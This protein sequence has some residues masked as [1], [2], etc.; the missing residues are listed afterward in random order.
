MVLLFL[1]TGHPLY[2]GIRCI[3][4][5]IALYIYTFIHKHIYRISNLKYIYKKIV[6]N[7]CFVINFMQRTE[8]NSEH[9]SKDFYYYIPICNNIILTNT[10]YSVV[11]LVM[12][13]LFSG[14]INHVNV[15]S[16]YTFHRVMNTHRISSLVITHHHLPLFADP[17]LYSRSMSEPSKP[18]IQHHLS[19]HFLSVSLLSLSVFRSL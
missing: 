9:N 17:G 18:F 19:V 16:L 6:R 5:L 13:A 7:I 11:H 2:R 8:D 15:R 14:S 4:F 1:A 3:T 12:G 10:S